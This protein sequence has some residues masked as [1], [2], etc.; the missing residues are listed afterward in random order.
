MHVERPNEL[1]VGRQGPY[2]ACQERPSIGAGNTARTPTP[3]KVSKG[4]REFGTERAAR[5]SPIDDYNRLG[6]TRLQPTTHRR[7][8]VPVD[9]IRPMAP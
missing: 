4:K 9:D 3:M 2:T 6:N 1:K 8:K 7:E 5:E